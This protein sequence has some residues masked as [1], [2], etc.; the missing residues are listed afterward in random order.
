[1]FVKQLF[2][3]VLRYSFPIIRMNDAQTQT[4]ISL[5]LLGA[6]AADMLTGRRVIKTFPFLAEPVLPV[7]GIIGNG[8]EF[9]LA[10]HE[11]LIRLLQLRRSFRHP[12]F[13][14]GIGQLQ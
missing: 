8:A 4:G 14:F 6:V 3:P 12:P 1:M 9:F 2:D 11:P 5:K 7:A 10:G 13:Q